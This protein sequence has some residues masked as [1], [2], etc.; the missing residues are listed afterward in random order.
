LC[1]FEEKRGRKETKKQN[2]TNSVSS[3]YRWNTYTKGRRR[4][5]ANL[6]KISMS[7]QALPNPENLSERQS[8]KHACKFA[9]SLAFEPM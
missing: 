2:N 5:R 1:R 3:F 7:K 8:L 9:T 6:K 4:K